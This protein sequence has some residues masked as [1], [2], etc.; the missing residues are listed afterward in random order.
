LQADLPDFARALKNM[1]IAVKLDT[2]G[3]RPQALRRLLDANLLD[4]VAMDIKAPAEKYPVAAGVPVDVGAIQQSIDLLRASRVAY[5][6]RTTVVPGLLTLRDIETIA[7]WVAGARKYVLQQFRPD[8]T[9]A[10]LG[11]LI[12][13]SPVELTSMTQAASSWIGS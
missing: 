2:N 12:P 8:N 11:E 9:L 7:R 6:F 13:Y 4:Y 3:A 5:E 1:G 10:S